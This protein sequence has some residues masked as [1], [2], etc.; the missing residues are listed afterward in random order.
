MTE[1]V[2]GPSGAGSVVLDLGP[3]IGVLVLDT[4]AELAGREI[5]VSP[6]SGGPGAHRTHSLVRERRTGA[7]TSYAAV[8]PG[9][10]A[11]DYTLW[12]DATTPA[13]TITIDSG[14]VTWHRW[15]D[16]PGPAKA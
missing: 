10:A 2:P 5:E 12:G 16:S 9:L 4:P 7:G 14:Q 3:G 11:G 8:Y 13:G 6:A 1:C 15:P